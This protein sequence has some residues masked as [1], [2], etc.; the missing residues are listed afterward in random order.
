MEVVQNFVQKIQ[1][2]KLPNSYTDPNP[3]SKK[4]QILLLN[5]AYWGQSSKFFSLNNSYWDESTNSYL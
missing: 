3:P 2:Q 5:N 4:L 1:T